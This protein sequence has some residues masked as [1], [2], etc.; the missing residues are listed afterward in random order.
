MRKLSAA[1][2]A[3][4][5]SLG[6]FGTLSLGGTE[7]AAATG[8]GH[9]NKAAF[10]SANDALDKASASVTSEA[11][12]LAEL[13]T[14]SADIKAMKKDV[15]AGAI[16]ATVR[17]VEAAVD[18]FIA[19]GN[20]NALNNAPGGGSVDTYC[21][22][23]GGG[24]PLPKYFATGKGTTFCATFVPIYQGVATASSPAAAVAVLVAHK[25]QIAQAASE[26]SKLPSSIRAKATSTI[27]TA[28]TAIA[29]NS[30]AGLG[31]GGNSP[32]SYVALYCG[33][34]Q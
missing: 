19:S 11:G 18:A 27:D 8:S 16:G 10:C 26:L 22:V 32:A 25:T 29:A 34:N 13:K 24:A 7:A 28:Q 33:Q 3:A 20:V 6:V 12:L 2:M 1:P 17:K 5:L 9:P 4:L 14:H 15:P 30:V 23:D 21:G 31:L